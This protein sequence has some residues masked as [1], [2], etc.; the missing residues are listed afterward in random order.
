VVGVWGGLLLQMKILSYNVRG[1]GG[2]EK[3]S[4]VKRLVTDKKPYVL[5]YTRI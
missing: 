4:E 2:F 1:L 3:R 5:M